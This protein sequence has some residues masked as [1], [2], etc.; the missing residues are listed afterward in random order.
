M[1]SIANER[2]R[3]L[4]RARVVSMATM[5]MATLLVS[6]SF[7]IN[8]LPSSSPAFGD[9]T[10]KKMFSIPP[11]TTTMMPI[12]ILRGG[13]IGFG[14]RNKGGGDAY[15]QALD[16]EIVWLE[17]QLRRVHKE[18]R[19]LTKNIAK[20]KLAQEGTMSIHNNNNDELDKKDAIEERQDQRDDADDQDDDLLWL[21][22]LE[23]L[24]AQKESLLNAKLQLESLKVDCD[25]KLLALQSE[26]SDSNYRDDLERTF[27]A[28]VTELE[29][30]LQ[31]LR[32]AT[33]SGVDKEGGINDLRLSQ[34]IDEACQ[35]V[36]LDFWK[37]GNR[38]LEEHERELKARF[39]QEL[40]EE[41]RSAKVA[42]EKQRKKM[43]A[44]AKV[45]AIKER[46][47]A[48]ETKIRLVQKAAK[49]D[50]LVAR[51]LE[52]HQKEQDGLLR[53]KEEEWERRRAIREDAER[54][55]KEEEERLWLQL[56]RELE[57]EREKMRRIKQR[58]E[59]EKRYCER[60][61]L[62]R[63]RIIQQYALDLEERRKREQ[64]D[65]AKNGSNSTNSS[66]TRS[67][68]N[69]IFGSMTSKTT[70]AIDGDEKKK[71]STTTPQPSHSLPSKEVAHITALTN[72]EENEDN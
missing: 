9:A 25:Q 3:V 57:L 71:E 33:I 36:I 7:A 22:N 48:A 50:K 64:Q 5:L 38:K 70:T 63:Q 19:V 4:V 68:F 55:A 18:K 53:A 1:P 32:E 21:A 28:R 56:E 17:Q 14:R 34:R 45:T 2:G 65:A 31:K 37:E 47:L 51:L 46:D 27:L 16:D 40:R 39:E 13:G 10:T 54:K 41:R 49:K 69:K 11:G 24:E 60:E 67:F 12:M 42:V 72:A 23:Q 43:R 62:E 20:R 6:P 29:T 30:S 44:L 8:S 61:E 52:K 59:E 66:Y 15:A 26:L 35:K 58:E